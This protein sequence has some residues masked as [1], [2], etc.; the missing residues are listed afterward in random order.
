MQRTPTS[1]E[2]PPVDL[3]DRP[4]PTPTNE[5]ATRKPPTR[6]WVDYSAEL[7]VIK[8]PALRVMFVSAGLVSVGFGVVGY[9]VPGMPGTVFFVIATWFFAQSSPRFYNWVLNHRLFGPLLRDYRAGKG[10]PGW[11][12]WYASAMILGFS[13]FS[14]WLVGIK[15]GNTWVGVAIAA[16]AIF[17][18]WY[19]FNVPTKKPE[20]ATPAPEEATRAPEE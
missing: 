9:V 15:R 20:A 7:R 10:I 16:A 6:E 18:V 8:H 2:A 12:K 1:A 17:G 5:R 3:P 4:A 14:T 19:V 11:V 13:A